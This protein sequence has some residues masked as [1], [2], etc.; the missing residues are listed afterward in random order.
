MSTQPR[1]GRILI[2]HRPE[3]ACGLGLEIGGEREDRLVDHVA[4]PPDFV[5]VRREG[6]RHLHLGLQRLGAA[7]LVALDSRPRLATAPGSTTAMSRNSRSRM[8]PGSHGEATG[9]RG[10]PVPAK[11]GSWKEPGRP[12]A[13]LWE[14]Q[15]RPAGRASPGVWLDIEEALLHASVLIN[16][17]VQ[18]G[19]RTTRLSRRTGLKRVCMLAVCAHLP[20]MSVWGSTPRPSL[21]L[22]DP[23]QGRRTIPFRTLRLAGKSGAYRIIQRCAR[24]R[25]LSRTCPGT[26]PRW[27]VPEA[28][29]D[30]PPRLSDDAC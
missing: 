6:G 28:R 29:L 12:T 21:A 7:G 5:H 14:A 9:L 3:Q 27:H 18:T 17:V 11:A 1:S 24:A 16:G 10:F 4:L 30:S 15:S 20:G 8:P 2:Y 19:Y 23:Y 22:D 13:Y 26:Y 25:K